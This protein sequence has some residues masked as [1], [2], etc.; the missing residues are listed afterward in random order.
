MVSLE[1]SEDRLDASSHQTGWIVFW[2]ALPGNSLCDQCLKIAGLVV[3][4]RVHPY[5]LSD[6]LVS[7]E[8]FEALLVLISWSSFSFHGAG[9]EGHES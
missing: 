3:F 2:K 6:R 8:R 7:K 9:G 1:P 5:F 4:G